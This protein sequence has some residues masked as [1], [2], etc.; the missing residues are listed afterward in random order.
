[1]A[2]KKRPV[3]LLLLAAAAIG[4]H[5]ITYFTLSPPVSS[6]NAVTSTAAIGAESAAA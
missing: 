6:T 3:I 5:A 2:I 1:M 4:A